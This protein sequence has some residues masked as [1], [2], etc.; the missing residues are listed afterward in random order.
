MWSTASEPGLS[1]LNSDFLAAGNPQS[2]PNSALCTEKENNKS[3]QTLVNYN[4][5]QAMTETPAKYKLKSFFKPRRKRY[6]TEDSEQIKR[7]C[8]I[9]SVNNWG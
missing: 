7:L 8:E 2:R 4:S 5:H 3:K 9:F 1:D 6:S